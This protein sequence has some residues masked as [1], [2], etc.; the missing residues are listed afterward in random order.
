[1]MQ[2]VIQSFGSRQDLLNPVKKPS[3]GLEK[4]IVAAKVELG[5]MAEVCRRF[6]RRG[7]SM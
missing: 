4:A 6:A 7:R 3:K 2:N 1:M 5:N